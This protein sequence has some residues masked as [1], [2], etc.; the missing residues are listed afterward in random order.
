MDGFSSHTLKFVNKDEVPV[1]V[2]IHIKTEAGIDN[3]TQEESVEMAGKDAECA[4]RDLHDHIESGKEAAWKFYIQ[5]MKYE[6][7]FTYKFDPFDITKVWPHKD[8][9]LIQIGRLVLNKNPENFFAEV[10]QAA[11]APSNMVPGIEPS[12]DKMLQGRLF[13][14]PDTH[15]HRLGG[16]FMQIPVNCPYRTTVRN[17]QRDGFMCVN[18]NQGGLPNYYPNSENYPV[19]NP[20]VKICPFEAQGMVARYEYQHPN[21]DFVQPGNL[22]RLMKSDEKSRLVHNIVGHL[23]V[24]KKEIQERQCKIFHRADPDYGTRVAKGLGLDTQKLFPNEK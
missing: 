10:E 8:Y 5:V 4:T 23:G 12:P 9:P 7:G 21:D 11:F 19:P 6:D 17:G 2:K 15:R 16:N 22:Y 1:W 20:S 13:S 3:F 18:G 14:Y 24:A